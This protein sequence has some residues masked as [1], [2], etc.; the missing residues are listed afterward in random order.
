MN[1]V[2]LLILPLAL[3]L[4]FVSSVGMAW[5]GLDMSGSVFSGSVLDMQV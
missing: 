5:L 2:D 1:R 4:V 3:V